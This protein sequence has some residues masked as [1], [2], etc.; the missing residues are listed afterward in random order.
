MILDPEAIR[1]GNGFA[2]GIQAGWPRARLGQASCQTSQTALF[3]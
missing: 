2:I 3:K 1:F